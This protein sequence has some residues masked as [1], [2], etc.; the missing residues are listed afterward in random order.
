MELVEEHTI[1]EG[2]TQNVSCIFWPSPVEN[3]P[4]NQQSFAYSGGEEKEV[5]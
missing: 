4:N 1:V 3:V 5:E 2:V